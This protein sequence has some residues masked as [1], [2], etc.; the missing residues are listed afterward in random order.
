MFLWGKDKELARLCVEAYNDWMVE[1][2]C[3]TSDGRLIPLCLV[4][5]W[6]VALAVAEVRRNA[7]RGVRAVAFSELPAYLDLPS[8]YTGYWDPFFAACAE[9]GTVL[10]HAHRIGHQDA[11]DVATT[12]PRPSRRRSS[13]AT[14]SGQPDRLPVLRCAPPLPDLQAALR[15]GADRLDPLRAGTHRRRVGHAPRLEPRPAQ[16]PGAAV[17][18]LLPPGP[19]L[20]LQGP[21]RGRAARSRRHR[22]RACSKPTTR[23]RTAPGRSPARPRPSSSG[24]SPQ[25]EID[26]IARGNAIRLLGLDL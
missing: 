3:G 23:T 18:L 14:A 2:W 24:T 11:E 26:K 7:A 10:S 22:Q 8:I 9:T 19:Q 5:L 12:R 4:P 1:E 15:G 17:D 6:D 25:D 20:L 21:G 13:S 16:L